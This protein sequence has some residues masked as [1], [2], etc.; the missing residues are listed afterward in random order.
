MMQDARGASGDQSTGSQSG[1]TGQ[2]RDTNQ[3]GGVNQS[4]GAGQPNGGATPEDSTSAAPNSQKPQGQSEKPNLDN[5]LVQTGK[6]DAYFNPSKKAE[7][8]SVAKFMDQNPDKF[9]KPQGKETWL[10]ELKEDNYLSGSEN[11]VFSKAIDMMKDA[12]NA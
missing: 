2:S 11:K 3:A 9:G 10:S 4:G 8:E 5:V 1:G 7:M 6:G 12:R